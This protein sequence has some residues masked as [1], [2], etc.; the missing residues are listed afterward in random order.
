MRVKAIERSMDDVAQEAR[1]VAARRRVGRGLD[2]RQRALVPVVRFHIIR[3][4]RIENV[5]KSQSCMVSKLR[6]IWKQIRRHKNE[7]RRAV[8]DAAEIEAAMA[9]QVTTMRVEL[10]GHSKPCMTEIYLHI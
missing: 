4:A 8:I 10:I 5:G 2:L 3:N 9:A 1:A 6:I 7:S